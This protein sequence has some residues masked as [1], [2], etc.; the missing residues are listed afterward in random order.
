MKNLVI[1]ESPTKAKTISSFLGK[2]F[3]IESSYGHMRDLPKSKLGIDVENN[4]DPHYIVPKAK[5]KQ[6][7]ALKKIAQKA[8]N[9]ILATDEDREG[10]A[11]AWHLMSALDLKGK[12]TQRIVFHE[13]TKEAIKE[14]LDNPRKID[15]RLVDAQQARRILDRL[16]GYELSPFLWRKVVKGLSAGRVQS[17]AVRLI[18]ERERE[19]QA[20]KPEEYWTLEAIFDPG[21][22]PARLTKIDSK[23]LDKFA[24]KN[25]K[26][27]KNI[28]AE[29]KTKKYSITS[30]TKKETKKSP[31]GPF[32]TS[33]LQ[34]ESNRRLGYSAKQTM[35]IAQQLYEGIKLGSEGSTGLITYM[36]TDSLTLSD[37]F[38][39]ETR[40]YIEK[41][42]GKEYLLP[43]AKTYKTKSKSAQEAHEAI[44]PSDITK[45]PESIKE[46]LD[47]KQF[48]L[49]QLIWQR[50]LASQLPDAIFDQ[51]SVNIDSD[52]KKYTFRAAGSIIKFDG[53][54]KI[55][56][57]SIKEAELPKLKENDAVDLKDL[58]ANQ[59]FTQPP[60]RYSDATLV[61][62]L[63]EHGIGRPSTYA[64]TIG[65]I[66]TR[67]Y[68]TREEKKLKP[69]EIAFLVNDLLVE[70][71]PSVVDY[72]FTAHMEDDLDQIA[73]GKIEWQP[74]I[75]E[76]YEP[77]KKNLNKKDMEIDK[78]ELTEEKT[79]EKCD[80][81]GAEMII[82]MGRYGKFLACSGFPECRNT[83]PIN[84]DGE[85][86]TNET[87]EKCDKCGKPMQIKRGRFG[88][89]LGC[90]G[91][92][93]CKNIKSIKKATGAKCPECNKGDIIEKR[94]KKGRT[95]Y[96]C[97]RYPDCKYALWQKPTGKN[98]P[99]C[100]SLLVF[101]A[102]GLIKCSNS[103]C[104]HEEENPD[105]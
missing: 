14:A 46:Y 66:I 86:A 48:R 31:L 18:I 34:Q 104:K 47:N 45:T 7:T 28:E 91:Y 82:K 15:Q 63:E 81:C 23:T 54:L 6:V 32:R 65:T 21:S 101:A 50:A 56:P 78:K 68:V 29:I 90:S 30:V 52:D 37:K 84:G 93:D 38:L 40:D 26:E 94:S 75:K 9:V 2:N 83:K 88:E 103:T 39:K 55:Y 8:E 99:E 76:F 1:V 77:F 4:F 73:E 44:R 43:K 16:V 69:A 60:A 97:E 22:F 33:T 24:V 62:V 64:P 51:T 13:I 74:V 61:K 36:R 71:F 105:A 35:M 27:A 11:I 49:Y 59:H 20:F 3:K 5:Q 57:S 96:S 58:Q 19:I 12:T 92:P 79:D 85:N 17:V 102:K 70:H 10:E 72:K 87:D 25:E 80:K 95:F 89:F 98:C 42:L 53:Y 67:G 100:K 41:D